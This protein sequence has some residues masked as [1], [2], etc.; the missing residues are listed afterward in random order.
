MA[1]SAP[2]SGL[3]RPPLHALSWPVVHDRPGLTAAVEAGLDAVKLTVTIP[4]GANRLAIYR[5]GPSSTQAYVRQ[6]DE[7]TVTASST[8]TARDFEP[9]IGVPLTYT[10]SS[11]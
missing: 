7:A 8:V 5:V 11:G 4:A 10:R 2:K 3:A 6:Y 9:P 1:W